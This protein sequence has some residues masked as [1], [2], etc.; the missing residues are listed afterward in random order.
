MRFVSTRLSLFP[1]AKPRE[2]SRSRGNKTHCF[3]LDQSLIVLLISTSQL[4]PRKKKK[5]T[6]KK[7]F[8]LL[9]LAEKFVAVSRSTTW[10]RASAMLLF[11]QGVGEFCST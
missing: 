9:R 10:S 8:A 4:K 2:I 6:A 3:P 5:K 7:L 1:E 11:L